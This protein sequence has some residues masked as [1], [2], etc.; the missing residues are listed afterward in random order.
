LGLIWF[1]S[2]LGV[3]VRDT[4][5]AVS[6]L[7]TLLMFLS[8]IFYPLSAVPESFRPFL[9]INPL[10]FVIAQVRGVLI[11]GRLPDW[12]GLLIYYVFSLGVMYLGWIWFSKTRKGFADVL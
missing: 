5:Q 1:L 10:V 2:S 12:S 11:F 7:V 9:Q 4:L 8:P 3:F 6:I